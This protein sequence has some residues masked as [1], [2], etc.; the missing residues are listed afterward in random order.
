MFSALGGRRR[1]ALTLKS[2]VTIHARMKNHLWMVVC[3]LW[4][5]TLPTAHAIIL[6][7]GG[8]L[9]N[10]TDPGGGAPWDEV[11]RVTN[12]SGTHVTSGSAVHLGGGYMLTANHVSLSQGYVSFNGTTTYQIAGGTAVQVTSEVGVI[13][14]KIFKLTENPGTLG[15]NLFPEYAKGYEA[16]FGAATHIGWGVGHTPGDTDNPWTWGNSATSD[17]RW[18]LNDFET[19]QALGYAHGGINYSFESLVTALDS[20]ATANEAAATLYDSGSG[21]FVQDGADQWF[22]AATMVTVSTNGSSTFGLEGAQDFNYSV[23][24]AEYAD[25]IASLMTD[26]IAVPE[27][28]SFALLL[29]LTSL[30]LIARRRV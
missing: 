23:R 9:T 27:P 25:E 21:L 8:N 5:S 13:D 10:T 28:A 4:G 12:A 2:V 16:S 20:D 3:L 24:I 1:F 30:V 7:G 15:V 22:L 14:L 19:A 17:K 6:L 18:G 26:P 11:A 29:G